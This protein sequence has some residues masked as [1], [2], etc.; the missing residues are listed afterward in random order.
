MS[1]IPRSKLPDKPAVPARVPGHDERVG[2]VGR[3]DAA[4]RHVLLTLDFD[5][6]NRVRLDAR[7]DKLLNGV[8]INVEDELFFL[9]RTCQC[10]P[11]LGAEVDKG[12]RI[13]GRKSAPVG[14]H[15]E[16]FGSEVVNDGKP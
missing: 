6:A 8:L 3:A 11:C 10:S 7:R 13:V 16:S 9:D 12:L 1:G 2:T 5:A 14:V 4:L 15:R